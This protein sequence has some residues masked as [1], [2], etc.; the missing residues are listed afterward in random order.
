MA[1]VDRMTT[2]TAT[3]NAPTAL[4]QGR[5]GVIVLIAFVVEL[6]AIGALANQVVTKHLV[7]FVANHH[8]RFVGHLVAAFTTYQWRVSAQPGD[9]ANE[10][11]AHA[12]LDLVVLALT[13]LLV[14]AVCRGAVTFARAFFGTWMA[15][16]VSTLIGQI[17]FDFI[18]PPTYPAGFSHLSGA[19]FTGPNGFGF[20]GGLM[21]GIVTAV[22]AAI[23]AVATRRTI[24][25]APAYVE[26]RRGEDMDEPVWTEQTMAYPREEYPPA[27]P[28]P[29][30]QPYQQPYQPSYDQPYTGSHYAGPAAGAAAAGS[31]TPEATQ[32]LRTVPDTEPESQSASAPEPTSET[33]APPA[34]KTEQFPRPPDDEDLGQHPDHHDL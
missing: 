15:V 14:L 31:S 3:A 25:L 26:E 9:R 22:F 19:V 33:A 20:I 8:D 27:Y 34:D 1:Y 24:R 18:S 13:A 23:F 2:G 21:L 6:V 29:Y 10:P 12:C 28:P 30:Q 4:K 5:P 7:N 11:L 32:Q 16:V 17:V